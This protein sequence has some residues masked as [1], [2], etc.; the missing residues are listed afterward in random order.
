MDDDV[1]SQVLSQA[2]KTTLVATTRS[3]RASADATAGAVKRGKEVV[4]KGKTEIGQLSGNPSHSKTIISYEQTQAH[5]HTQPHPR[6]HTH[7]RIRACTRTPI[8]TH[9]LKQAQMLPPFITSY[10]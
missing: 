8:L 7:T 6:A 2:A 4:R 9:A 10:F 5:A 1:P 3:L